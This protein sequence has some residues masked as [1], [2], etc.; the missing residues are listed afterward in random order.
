VPA[1]ACQ[2]TG[3]IQNPHFPFNQPQYVFVFFDVEG[4]L[5]A[6]DDSPAM[7]NQIAFGPNLP[8]FSWKGPGSPRSRDGGAVPPPDALSFYLPFHYFYPEWWWDT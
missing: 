7:D 6:S 1:L 8:E 2:F 3:T 4:D 5:V